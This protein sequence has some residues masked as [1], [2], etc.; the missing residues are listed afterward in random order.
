MSTFMYI[1]YIGTITDT[2]TTSSSLLSLDRVNWGD[3]AN[4]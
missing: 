4:C 1:S 3:L 2:N